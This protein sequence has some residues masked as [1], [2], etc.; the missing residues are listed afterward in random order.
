[1]LAF[2]PVSVPAT[3]PPPSSLLPQAPPSI[4]SRE[5][6]P[7]TVL[8]CT[9]DRGD[10]IS[11]TI[12]SILA[13]AYPSFTLLIVDQSSDRRTEQAVAAFRS[14]PRLVY[15]RTMSQGLS[16]A[17]NTGLA[18]SSTEIVAITDDDCEVPPHW[19]AEMV[20][21]FLRHPRVGLVFCNVVAA[22]H[23]SSEGFIPFNLGQRP[24]LITDL[25]HWATNGGVNIGIGAGMAVRRPAARSI[26]GFNPLFGS[27]SYFRSGNDLEF[28]LTMLAAGHQIYRT[29]AVDVTHH[30]FRT[31]AQG[32]QLIRSNLFGVGAAYGSLLRRGH[33]VSLRYCMGTLTRTVLA[34]AL[35]YLVRLQ[36]PRVL[37]RAAW[38]LRGLAEGFRVAPASR[39]SGQ[40]ALREAEPCKL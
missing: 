36:A 35:S 33:W 11:A 34:P 17:L 40:P 4:A 13:C 12:R 16:V 7:V 37:G 14:D 6:P 15:V 25:E 10:S 18:L 1:M 32:R 23:N 8:I 27:G 3:D 39:A 29:V 31:H 5:A 22:P 2:S 38:L 21:P 20:A 30:G 19:I 28:S 26:G 24:L 9:R